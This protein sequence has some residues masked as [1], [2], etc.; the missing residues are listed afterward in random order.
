MEQGRG[1]PLNIGKDKGQ[2]HVEKISHHQKYSN[3]W[4]GA[5]FLLKS[6]TRLLAEFFHVLPYK[7]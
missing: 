1:F 5:L 6:N 4:N 7:K 3:V 2:C